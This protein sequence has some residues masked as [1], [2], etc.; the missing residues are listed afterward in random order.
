MIKIVILGLCLGLFTGCSGKNEKTVKDN[1]SMTTESSLNR[2]T[3]QEEVSSSANVEEITF[4]PRKITDYEKPDKLDGYVGNY[5]GRIE[6]ENGD[7]EESY[8]SIHKDGSYTYMDRGYSKL[9]ATPL[10]YFDKDNN[11]KELPEQ[12][13]EYT[14]FLISSGIVLD[15]FDT[16]V[17]GDLTTPALEKNNFRYIDETGKMNSFQNLEK[18]TLLTNMYDLKEIGQMDYYENKAKIGSL[19]IEKVDSN[20][21]IFELLSK[22]YDEIYR[23]SLSKEFMNLNDFYQKIVGNTAFIE[24]QNLDANE[25]EKIFL[26]NGKKVNVKYGLKLKSDDTLTDVYATDGKEVFHGKIENNV[27]PYKVNPKN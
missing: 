12:N 23:D 15:K 8:L 25:Y 16:L 24:Y 21:S 13:V 22:N 5:K 17:F 3:E 9:D 26:E 2:E 4:D 27:F 14:F 11:F 1:S 7:F 20:E 6:K 10:T 18:R 19:D